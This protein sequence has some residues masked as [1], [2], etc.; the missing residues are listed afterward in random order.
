MMKYIVNE[1]HNPYYNLAFEEFVLT[2]MSIDDDY[3]LLWQNEPTIVIGKNQNTLEEINSEYVKEK[4]IHVVRRLSGGGA[5]YHDLGNL[6]FTFIVN[7]HQDDEFDFKKFT[8]PVINALKKI[9]VEAYFNSR[10]DLEIDGKKFSGNA[11]YIKKGRL[12]HHGTLMF[13][14]EIE[15]LVRALSI[16]DDKIISKG[17]KSVRSRVTNIADYMDKK[18]T[19]DEFKK[20]LLEYLQLELGGF[21][22]YHLT[23]SEKLEVEALMNQRYNTWD[24]NYGQ[25]PAFNIKK[26]KKFDHGK[27]EAL[28]DVREGYIETIKFYGDFF[29]NG[30]MREIEALLTGKKYEEKAI[31]EVLTDIDINK[32][33]LG[34]NS[35]QLIEL[36]I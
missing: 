28:I 2:E 36:F 18:I 7:H 22:V 20:I 5:V 3:F 12:L 31:R 21:Q 32:Y 25:S 1:S 9:G 14:S 26:Q 8:K 13:N 30:D 11:Q 6:N 10:N 15:E 24:W 17:I 4:N 16:S 19:L 29:G 33:F 34:F 27:V 35:D 23:E